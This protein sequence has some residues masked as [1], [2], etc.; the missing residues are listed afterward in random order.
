MGSQWPGMGKAL[1]NIPIFAAAIEKCQKAL[2]PHGV[3]L[4]NIITTEDPSI[5]DNILNCFVG[6]AACQV[7]HLSLIKRL[8]YKPNTEWVP[9]L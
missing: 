6:I 7:S 1:L 9:N 8:A 2:R 5:F 4:F 3:D